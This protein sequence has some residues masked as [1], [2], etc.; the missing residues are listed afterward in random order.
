MNRQSLI[1]QDKCQFGGVIS[2]PVRFHDS[3]IRNFVTAQR[4]LARDPNATTSPSELIEEIM[5]I[6]SKY[7]PLYTIR[8]S[9]NDL[10]GKGSKLEKHK[11]RAPQ[12][13][14]TLNIERLLIAGVLLH[15]FSGQRCRWYRYSSHILTVREREYNFSSSKFCELLI[16]SFAHLLESFYS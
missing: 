11:S 5:I 10:V 16:H 8:R 1:S 6:E 9:K 7:R 4:A 15:I 12:K 3:P 2:R 13:V 14:S